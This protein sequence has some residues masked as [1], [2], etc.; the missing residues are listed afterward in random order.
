M[1]ADRLPDL[2]G[3]MSL[4]KEGVTPDSLVIICHGFGANGQDLIGL[5]ENW[6]AMFPG[7][8][9]LAPNAPDGCPGNPGGF[10]WFPITSFDRAERAEG[11]LR[12]APILDHY[13]DQKLEE[14]G[15][16]EN[17]LVLAGFSQGTMMALHVG[18]RREKQ[19]AGILGYSGALILPEKLVA[20]M[21]SK[22]PVL[23]IHGDQDNVVP[24]YMM[25][26]TVGALEAAGLTVEKHISQ[27]VAHGIAPDGLQK[28]GIFIA[29]AL[30]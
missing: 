26:E 14:Y 1:S 19:I 17:R 25:F 21:N 22:P 4:P 6:R 9:F 16:D 30:G 3:P 28:G 2:S 29:K 24:A 13:I 20:E 7:T 11:V 27:G 5:A 10:Q 23:L 15:L 8:V 18:L 12:A